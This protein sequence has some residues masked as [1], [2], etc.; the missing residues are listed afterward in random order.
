LNEDTL[1]TAI[2]ALNTAIGI[3]IGLFIFKKLDN[4]WERISRVEGKLA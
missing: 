4:L 2:I 1:I 3:P